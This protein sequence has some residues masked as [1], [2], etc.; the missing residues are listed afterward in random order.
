M[1]NELA[2]YNLGPMIQQGSSGTIIEQLIVTSGATVQG[3]TVSGST[4]IYETLQ[5]ASG[6]QAS[7]LS[8]SGQILS[9]NG[10]P[11]DGQIGALVELPV[12]YP[13]GYQ[14]PLPNT[15]GVIA[16]AM[17][18]LNG[19]GI[20]PA[21]NSGGVH[22]VAYA[23]VR[24]LVSG[25]SFSGAIQYQRAGSLGPSGSVITTNLPALGGALDALGYLNSGVR[26]QGDMMAFSSGI[27]AWV[28]QWGSTASGQVQLVQF[29]AAVG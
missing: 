5:V 14:A 20:S 19:V 7:T 16:R 21:N 23:E 25:A 3:L 2:T 24:G 13:F 27:S 8:L 1:A 4:I 11:T 12:T 15:S 9:V 6:I 22:L 26:I 29:H 17:L 10:V 18:G 28:V